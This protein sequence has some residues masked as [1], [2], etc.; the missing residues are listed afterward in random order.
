MVRAFSLS[1][2]GC[3]ALAACGGSGGGGVGSTPAPPTATPA[4]TPAPSPSNTTLTNLVASQSFTNDVASTNILFDSTT[5][6]TINGRLASGALTVAY[7]R[8]SNSYSLSRS[9]VSQT[10][11][12]SDV[13]TNSADETRY[14]KS[15]ANGNS[16]LTIAR[17]PY[18]GGV[19]RRFVGLGFWQ[20]NTRADGRQDTLFDVFTYGLTTP[21]SAVPRTGTAAFDIDVFGLSAAPGREA[22][23]IQG[24]GL[25]SADFGAGVF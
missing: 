5:A 10:F 14:Q 9:G 21:A 11:A 18:S 6:T 1:L 4:P 7:D 22:Y 3:F 20:R 23:T 13:T 15:D 19:A 24:Q 2:A 12:P 17:T 25:F 8:S 16:Y